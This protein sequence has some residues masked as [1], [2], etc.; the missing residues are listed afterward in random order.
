MLTG[1]IFHNL[2]SLTGI[3]FEMSTWRGKNN[4]IAEGM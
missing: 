4:D 3:M 2:V 1:K